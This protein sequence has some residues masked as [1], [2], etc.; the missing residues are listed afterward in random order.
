MMN[1]RKKYQVLSAAALVLFTTVAAVGYSNISPSEANANGS[2]KS[3][4]TCGQNGKTLCTLGARGPG[5]GTIFFI[6]YHNQ[7]ASFNF[8]EVAPVGWQVDRATVDPILPWCD[9]A[10]VITQQQVNNWT[11]RAVGKGAKNT[12]NMLKV[13]HSGAAN[14]IEEYNKSSRTAVKDWFLPS[15][16][17]L[18]LLANNAQGLADLTATEYWSSSEFSN[19]GA[20][21]E[22]IGRGYQGSAAKSALL[23]V[24]PIRLF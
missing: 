14:A 5:K 21:V 23:A 20:W 2:Y 24:R 22:S 19:D 18:I 13:C 16:G 11:N 1:P 8:L 12:S 10:D 6:D 7:Y 3:S 17:D 4:Y 15:T 9:S